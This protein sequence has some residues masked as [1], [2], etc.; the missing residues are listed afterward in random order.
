MEKNS[1]I[2]KIMEPNRPFSLKERVKSFSYALNG[3]KVF[4][5]T[6]HN[7]WIH[8]VAAVFTIA[9]GFVFNINTKEWY[10]IIFAIALVFVCEMF[11][12]A[13]EFLCDMVNKE[14]HP[15]IEK[16]KDVSAAAVLIASIAALLVGGMVFVPKLF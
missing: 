14:F 9:L 8:L 15:T 3:L 4:F 16:I 11:N 5:T 6:Q 7:A 10:V 12:T 13:I 1:L 2:I